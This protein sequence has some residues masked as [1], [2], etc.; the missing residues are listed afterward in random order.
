MRRGDRELLSLDNEG[1]SPNESEPD[2]ASLRLYGGGQPPR[3]GEACDQRRRN[4]PKQPL[5]RPGWLRRARA[6]RSVE[7]PGRPGVVFIGNGMDNVL[8]ESITWVTAMAGSRSG[9]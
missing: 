9:S 2:S 7:E 1:A 3:D 4:E 5:G 6:E 8:G